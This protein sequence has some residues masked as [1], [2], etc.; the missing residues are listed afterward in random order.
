MLNFEEFDG[1]PALMRDS[2]EEKL[3][4]TIRLIYG[5]YNA[6]LRDYTVRNFT[7]EQISAMIFGVFDLAN[8]V[9]TKLE[10]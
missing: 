9:K 8:K 7:G 3:K 10:E 2:L 6:S 5:R 1:I 4:E